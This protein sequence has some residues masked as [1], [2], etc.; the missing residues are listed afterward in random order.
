VE[1]SSNKVFMS[2]YNILFICTHNSARSIIGE[3][4]ASTH[5]SG[6]FIGYSAGLHPQDSVSPFA[7]EIADELQYSRDNLRS[8]SW[9]EF[10]APDAPT[11]NFII[12]LY[13]PSNGEAIPHLPGNPASAYWIF[14]DPSNLTGNDDVKRRAMRAVMVGLKKRVE[15]L[16]SLP[17]EQLDAI[18]IQKKLAEINQTA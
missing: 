4:V 15:I 8:K 18:A 13:D 11:M 5:L 16:A 3:A 6:K 12:S 10:N 7:L 17:I 1:L 9:E 14:P 2:K